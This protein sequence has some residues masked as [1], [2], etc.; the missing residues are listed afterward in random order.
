MNLEIHTCQKNPLRSAIP[1]ALHVNN[2]SIVKSGSPYSNHRSTPTDYIH[3]FRNN[4]AVNERCQLQAHPCGRVVQDV[5]R[6]FEL[7]DLV[8]ESR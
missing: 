8:F 3:Y 6:P 7:L 5:L 2:I 1:Y 4:A